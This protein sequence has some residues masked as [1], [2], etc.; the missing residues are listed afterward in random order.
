MLGGVHPIQALP[1][2]NAVLLIWLAADA[3][4]HGRP[5]RVLVANEAGLDQV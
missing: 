2:T 1:Q 3:S 4:D 5:A